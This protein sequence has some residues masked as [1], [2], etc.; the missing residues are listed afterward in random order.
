MRLHHL[1]SLI[2]RFP[3]A[4]D[5]IWLNYCT[6][7]PSPGSLFQPTYFNLNITVNNFMAHRFKM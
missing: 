6:H 5:E 2:G 3:I 4:I 7:S 1:S